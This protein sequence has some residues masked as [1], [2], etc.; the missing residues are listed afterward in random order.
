MSMPGADIEIA[1]MAIYELDGK[2]PSFA[3][4]KLPTEAIWVAPEAQVMGNIQIE[5]GASIWFGAV[6][7]GDNELITIGRD[8]NFQ[9]LA[10]GH[11]DPG[12]PLTIGHGCTIG[13]KAILHGCTIGDNSLVGMG[14]MVMNGATVGK[15]CLIAAGSLVSEGKSIPD[16]SLVIGSP[17]K[18]VRELDEAAINMLKA[19]AAHYAANARRF[20]K[21][22]KRID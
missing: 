6:L 12:F 10:M 4:E 7:R 15:N 22:L 3:G 11:T 14:A 17:G 1:S 5:E 2:S 16:N 21:G 8:S 18:I 9:D 20:T 19:S 13:H